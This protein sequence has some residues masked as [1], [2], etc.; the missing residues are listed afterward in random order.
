MLSPGQAAYHFLA[1]YQNGKFVPAYSK[2]PSMDAK[3]FFAKLKDHKISTFIVNVN[4]G[5]THIKGMEIP[6][7][8]KSRLCILAMTASVITAVISIYICFF[9]NC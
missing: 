3:A 4:E 1:G 7:D 5:Q 2:F 8:L 9:L 6:D